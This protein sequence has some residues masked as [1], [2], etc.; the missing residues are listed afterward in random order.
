[1][2]KFNT[3]SQPDKLVRFI[4]TDMASHT[5]SGIR[6]TDTSGLKVVLCH[7]AGISFTRIKAFDYIHDSKFME[8]A[9]YESDLV[10]IKTAFEFLNRWMAP[11]APVS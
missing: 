4:T 9:C 6:I 8:F 7:Q 2:Q 11:L 1:M 3:Q 5:S 10:K